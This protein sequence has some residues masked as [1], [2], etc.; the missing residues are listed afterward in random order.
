MDDKLK[1]I[2]YKTKYRNLKNKLNKN[3]KIKGGS[4]INYVYIVLG[5]VLTTLTTL[6]GYFVYNSQ[7][8]A[9]SKYENVKSKEDFKSVIQKERFQLEYE[10]KKSQED[11][12]SL[13]QIDNNRL[14]LDVS[15][16]NKEYFL[17]L[18]KAYEQ[19]NIILLQQLEKITRYM[20]DS[21][22]NGILEEL[23]ENNNNIQQNNDI[24]NKLKNK[25]ILEG[26]QSKAQ[27]KP[28]ELEYKSTAQ[29]NPNIQE[30]KN[31]S[32]D[33]LEL[34]IKEL[35]NKI[36]ELKI[37]EPQMDRCKYL[38]EYNNLLGKLIDLHFELKTDEYKI[39][40]LASV[41][42]KNFE[43][44]KKCEEAKAAARRK[45]EEA[46]ATARRKDEYI[47]GKMY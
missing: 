20:N 5:V 1:Y 21:V 30:L 27:L 39:R 41:F 15:I 44:E 4:N 10:I 26:F 38:R 6:G 18:N 42:D 24:I 36:K 43:I 35:E 33:E 45:D 28:K 19:R 9:G 31:K 37:I 29:L 16:Y 3:S 13:I 14:P 47:W 8:K 11:F 2:K 12:K 34:E 46:K 7:D 22:V 40:Q 25:N 32:K 17:N 23:K